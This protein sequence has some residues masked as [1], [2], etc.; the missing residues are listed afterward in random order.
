MALSLL[1]ALSQQG[2]LAQYGPDFGNCN[3]STFCDVRIPMQPPPA[4]PLMSAQLAAGL[5]ARA[6]RSRRWRRRQERE[7]ELD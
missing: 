4:A 2:V 3:C 7:R 6:S 1:L 5:A